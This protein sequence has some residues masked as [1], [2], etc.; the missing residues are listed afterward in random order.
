[1]AQIADSII[2]TDPS[3]K[4]WSSVVPCSTMGLEPLNISIRLAYSQDK[5]KVMNCIQNCLDIIYVWNTPMIQQIMISAVVYMF[6]HFAENI[7]HM[8]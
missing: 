7:Q 8:L 6:I 4:W 3:K 2:N 1:M 5:K